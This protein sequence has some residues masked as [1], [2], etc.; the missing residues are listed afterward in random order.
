MIPC[1]CFSLPSWSHAGLADL[2]PGVT[3]LT[4]A[5]HR[6][7][8]G[9]VSLACQSLCSSTFNHLT[10]HICPFEHGHDAS[11]TLDSW[12][13]VDTWVLTGS[14][15]WLGHFLGPPLPIRTPDLKTTSSMQTSLVP[16]TN[17]GFVILGFITIPFCTTECPLYLFVYMFNIP[18][19]ISHS[20]G[21]NTS[22]SRASAIPLIPLPLSVTPVR[23]SVTV[24]Y[25]IQITWPLRNVIWIY[26]K[27]SHSI[28]T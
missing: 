17:N 1:L 3:A 6:V 11:A 13:L 25:M 23:F 22:L 26:P 9:A 19:Q 15:P 8:S 14:E 21:R 24:A 5:F 12:G 4:H 20:V 2:S 18:C 28:K 16:Y 27:C 7:D 10:H